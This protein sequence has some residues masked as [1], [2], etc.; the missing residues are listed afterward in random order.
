[1]YSLREIQSVWQATS[2]PM[3]LRRFIGNEIMGWKIAWSDRMISFY[4]SVWL[5]I[6][7]LEASF[8][9]G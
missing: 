8:G 2:D 9:K 7:Y 4:T 3:V 6:P 1:M 5:A